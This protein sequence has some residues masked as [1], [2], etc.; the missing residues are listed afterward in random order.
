MNHPHVLGRNGMGCLL[1]PTCARCYYPYCT[2]ASFLW[3]TTH[4]ELH[5]KPAFQHAEDSFRFIQPLIVQVQVEGTYYFKETL[6]K[7][8]PVNNCIA[9]KLCQCAPSAVVWECGGEKSCVTP[10]RKGGEYSSLPHCTL[11]QNK[12]ECCRRFYPGEFLIKKLNANE[13][14]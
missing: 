1:H 5:P 3:D 9:R 7:R 12:I 8:K 14:D 6:G 10:T 11:T 4:L 2:Q 13:P